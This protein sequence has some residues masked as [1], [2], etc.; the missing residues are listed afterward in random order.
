MTN[1]SENQAFLNLNIHSLDTNLLSI[2]TNRK[3][4]KCKKNLKMKEPFQTDNYYLA[5]IVGP[6]E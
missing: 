4:V 5:Y 1:L 3:I 6:W 2:E